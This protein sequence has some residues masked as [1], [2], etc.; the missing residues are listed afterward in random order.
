MRDFATSDNPRVQAQLD[1]LG[2]LTLPT[3]R[4]GL[5]VIHALLGDIHIAEP[6]CLIGFAGQRVIQDT[7]RE[8]LP[9]GFQRAEYLYEHGMV[10]MVVH[11]R[12]LKERLAVLLGYLGKKEAA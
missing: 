1:R 8:K 10:D 4:L 5:E 9:E 7:I 6:E 2:A 12:D 3:G 11:R